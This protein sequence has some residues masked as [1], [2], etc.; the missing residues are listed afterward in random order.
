MLENAFSRKL[1]TKIR[2]MFPDAILL[3]GNSAA[4]Q[5]IPDWILFYGDRWAT[6]EVKKSDKEPYQP[7]QPYFIDKMNHMSF[8]AMICPQNE[9]DVLEQLEIHMQS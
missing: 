5:G 4:Q 1:T 3:K 7:N 8:S 6:L 9:A 2:Q